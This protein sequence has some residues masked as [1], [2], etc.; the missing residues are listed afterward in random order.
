MKTELFRYSI[1]PGIV[2]I[3]EATTL[4]INTLEPQLAFTADN[5]Y[6]IE[7]WGLTRVTFSEFATHDNVFDVKAKDGKLVFTFSFDLESEYFVR[8]FE[9]DSNK[10]FLQLSV[11]ALEEDLYALRPLKGDFHIHSCRSD[12]KESPAVVAANYRK[13]GFDFMAVTD[14]HRYDPSKEAQDAYA[15]VPLGMLIL[16]GE[17]VHTPDNYVHVINFGGDSSVNDMYRADEDRYYAD[18]QHIIDTNDLPYEDKF[19]YA[20]NMWAVEKIRATNGLAVFCH[21]HWINNTYNVPDSLSIAFLK[22]NIFDAFE[23]IGG[24]SAHENNMQTALYHQLRSEGVKIP[25]T[26]ASDSHGTIINSGLFNKMYTVVF[27]QDNTRDSIVHAVKDFMSVAVHVYED[28]VNYNVHG[29]YRL[30]SYAG[31]LIENYFALTQQLC[32]EEGILMR[33]HSLGDSGATQR[34][35]QLKQ[36]T[37]NFYTAYAGK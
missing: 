8:V 2:K 7:V 24:Q 37:D 30:V 26:G 17:E 18:I 31:F 3:G 34:L 12:G 13:S 1:T 4:C 29:S 5:A 11:Y 19:T 27:A 22:N 9:Q 32:E 10:H 28:S 21:P 25:I 23:V 15:D 33:A 6:K 36:R 14:H 20:A 35:A 16:N